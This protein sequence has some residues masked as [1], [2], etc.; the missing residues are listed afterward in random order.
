MIAG[1]SPDILKKL[2]PEYKTK[3]LNLFNVES[4]LKLGAIGC[5]DKSASSEYN[6]LRH[7]P[8]NSILQLLTSR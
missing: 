5:Y 4:I 1:V 7:I 3:E 6:T 8:E 2:R